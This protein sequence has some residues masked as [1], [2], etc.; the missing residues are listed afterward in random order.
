MA[1][2]YPVSAVVG[3]AGVME[4]AQRTWISSTAATESTGLAATHAVLDWHERSDVPER[5]AAAG[6]M[7][8]QII[9]TALAESPW[10]GVS[11]DGPPVMWRLCSDTPDPLDALV[12][13]AARHGLLLKRGAYQFGAIAH[14]DAVLEQ[15]AALMSPIMQSLLPGPRRVED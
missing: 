5:M 13:A 10:V 15:V 8:Q 1:N 14:D 9:G 7:L 11:V 3:R 4:V 6:G 12:A 2:G